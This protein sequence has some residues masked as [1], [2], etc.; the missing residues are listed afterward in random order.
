[1]KTKFF[2]VAAIALILSACTTGSYVSTGFVD[3]IYFNPAD[4]PPP[5]VMEESPQIVE[6][7]AEKS[8]RR[9]IIS[10]IREND[11]GSQTMNNYIFDGEDAGEYV[12]A[13]LYDMDQMQLEGSDTTV[14]YDENE[15]KYVINNYYDGTDIDF[16]YRIN[17]FHRP[18][19]RF[20]DPF[21]WNDWY[22]DSWYYPYSS[23]YWSMGW[24]WGYD[25][26]GWG[27]SPWYGGYYGG[28]YGG[29]YSPYSYYGW[30]GGWGYP[31]YSWG[32]PY[33]GYYWGG[34]YYIDREDYRYG[35]RRDFNTL[36]AG[37]GGYGTRTSAIT[38]GRDGLKSADL[39][40]ERNSV[41]S[42]E[43]RER[44][45]TPETTGSGSVRAGT[46]SQSRAKTEMRR[47]TNDQPAQRTREGSTAVSRSASG[48]QG[49]YTRPATSARSTGTPST[50]Q[51]SYTPSYN[52]QRSTNRSSYNVQGSSRPSAS[53]STSPSETVKS[54]Q[55][56]ATTYSRPSSSSSSSRTYRSTSTY[57]RSSSSGTVNRSTYSTPSHSTY[58]APS[59][60]SSSPSYSAPSRSSSSG[61][62]SGSS[63]SSSGNY[64]GGGSSSGGGGGRSSGGSGR[65]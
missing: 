22:W 5:V 50:D 20:Y 62:Y 58:S 61:S 2:L 15:V 27:Y 43:R 25:P 52:Q 14:Y 35:H 31:Y 16:A 17:R 32:Y 4:V 55:R 53:G 10:E 38:S 29:W 6:E 47:G 9:I 64:G 54:T 1:M 11:E 13:Q 33:Y 39:R 7:E 63:S 41:S 23:L 45:I 42:G 60:G 34:G 12:D 49:Q 19:S 3:G 48:A 24:G 51:N 65:R 44:T 30:G 8:A 26:W 28:Y 46:G 56:P 18:Y 21:Y 59:S 40:N 37:G 57:N 36:V